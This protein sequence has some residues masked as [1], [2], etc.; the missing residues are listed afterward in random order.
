[1]Q[2]K[3]LQMVTY[4]LLIIGGINW[5]LIGI[6][7]VNIVNLILGGSPVV[8]KLVYVAVGLSAVYD[9]AIMR[10]GKMYT[11]SKKR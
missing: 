11:T 1:M 3:T 10:K 5:G 8:E 9:I 6:L 4:I 2:H 7:N